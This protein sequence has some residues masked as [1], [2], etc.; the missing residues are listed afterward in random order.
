MVLVGLAI[1]I[2][3]PF[4]PLVGAGLPAV[5]PVPREYVIVY[6]LSVAVFSYQVAVIVTVP[7]V[8]RKFL[9]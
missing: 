8:E 6:V 9:K 2:Y 5:A 7:A 3:V 4:V 1:F